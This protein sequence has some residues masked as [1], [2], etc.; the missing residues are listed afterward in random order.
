MLPIAPFTETSGTYI[1]TEGRVQSFVAAVKPL[2]DTRPAWKVLRVLGNMLGLTGFEQNS[3]EDVRAEA[4]PGGEAAVQA[5]LS[6]ALKQPVL[7]EVSVKV[8]GIERIGEVPLYQLDAITRRAPALQATQDARPPRAW[9]NAALLQRLGVKEG[10]ALILRQG[11]GQATLPAAV[12]ASLPDHCV[13]VA[14]AHPLTAALGGMFADIT[15][16]RA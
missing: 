7:G 13:R 1:N 11:N 4:L 10:D 16:E 8:N 3:S 2:G 15:V 6:N 12:D 5:S 9:V 14:A